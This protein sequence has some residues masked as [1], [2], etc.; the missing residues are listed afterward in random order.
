MADGDD[1]DDDADPEQIHLAPNA[2]ISIFPDLA[3][4]LDPVTSIETHDM[5]TEEM[6]GSD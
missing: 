5:P 1:D 4:Q 2:S 3:Q 6:F